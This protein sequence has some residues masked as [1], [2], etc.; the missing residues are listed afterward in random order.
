MGLLNKRTPFLFPMS[1][2][3][4][5]IICYARRLIKNPLLKRKQIVVELIHPDQGSVSKVTIREKLAKM[6]DSKPEHI[7]VFGLHSKFGGG[8]SSGFLA[9]TTML[10]PE[11]STTPRA[12]SLETN[13]ELSL[14]R[15]EES[16]SRK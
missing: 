14:E 1:E 12:C 9:S 15:R 10:M 2:K 6:F 7:A 16:N 4:E 5:N 11:R 13:S 3:K 8:R